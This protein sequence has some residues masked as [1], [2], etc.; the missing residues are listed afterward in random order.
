MAR[1]G[2]TLQRREFLGIVDGAAIAWPHAMHAQEG[3]E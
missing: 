1:W 2:L 3:L